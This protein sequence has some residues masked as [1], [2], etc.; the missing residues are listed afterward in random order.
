MPD[1]PTRVKES[2]ESDVKFIKRIVTFKFVAGIVIIV[3]L[4]IGGYFL[5]NYV[6]GLISEFQNK[7]GI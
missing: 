3:G 7:F 5:Y 1:R 2:V 6:V 4:I